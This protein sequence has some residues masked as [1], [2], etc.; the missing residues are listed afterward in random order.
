[1]FGS[2]SRFDKS[3]NG[4]KVL[5][6]GIITIKNGNI[7]NVNSIDA[8]NIN[9]LKNNVKSNTEAI[10][11]LNNTVVSQGAQI[12]INT[13]NIYTI[14]Y[15][16][17]PI[18]QSQIDENTANITVLQTTTTNLQ[19][20]VTTNT[21]SINSLNTTSTN[22]QSQITN[23]T[24]SINTINNTSIPNLQSQINTINNII[25]E[26]DELNTG[27]YNNVLVTTS[28]TDII[29]SNNTESSTFF[30]ITMGK[31]TNRRFTM[32]IPIALRCQ[33]NSNLTSG[34]ID[35]RLTNL[36]FRI[37]KNG[38]L[39][40]SYTADATNTSYNTIRDSGNSANSNPGVIS[41]QYYGNFN[42]VFIPDFIDVDGS[43]DV[44]TI[45]AIPTITWTGIGSANNVY[46]VM[47]NTT[48]SNT[49]SIGSNVYYGSSS[50]SG[51][52]ALLISNQL[53]VNK[54]NV[55]LGAGLINYIPLLEII[56]P[57]G[58]IYISTRAENPRYMLGGFGVWEPIND[59]FLRGANFGETLGGV[60]GSHSH[61]HK[62]YSQGNFNDVLRRAI[63]CNN[64]V[65]STNQGFSYDEAG[66]NKD[67]IT[68]SSGSSN[69][70][71]EDYSTNLASNLP[72]YYNV[73]MWRRIA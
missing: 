31:N 1:M 18:L 10:N 47:I 56:M 30:T 12:N 3:I 7:T 51:Y 68:N 41:R 6:D 34:T 21:T 72:P 14:L 64:D 11:T 38:N 25:P 49:S 67:F 57:L 33:F 42:L 9:N 60:G 43:N 15:M 32:T 29:T 19:T 59:R 54:P 66:N 26:L 23:N 53:P 46:T 4:V 2:S 69:V 28:T 70:I 8:T 35:Y 44:Y 16:S 61:N 27:S 71:V 63:E 62:W 24:N 39:F 48:I 55:Y 65:G 52:Q 40:S 36:V 22:L 37:Y 50:T 20:Q 13:N 17:I 45:K 73:L 5:S 58:Y